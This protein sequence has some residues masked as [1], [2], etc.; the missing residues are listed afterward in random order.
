MKMKPPLK[1]RSRSARWTV[2]PVSAP[3]AEPLVATLLRRIAELETAL[4]RR[5]LER[6]IQ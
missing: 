5:A 3:P 6:V 2:E 4:G 1:T